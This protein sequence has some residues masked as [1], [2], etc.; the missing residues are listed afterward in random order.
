MIRGKV[1]ANQQALVTIEVLDGEGCSQSLQVV[2][3]TGFT[4]YLTLP[5]GSNQRLGLRSVGQRTFE[6]A[7]G[8]LVAFDAYLAVV[9]WHGSQIDALVLQSDSAPLLGMALIWGSRI[10]VDA[11]TGGEVTIEELASAP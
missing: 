11:L 2:L 7:S 3:D 1:D 5:M 9:S 6:L 10:I 4:G 8:E